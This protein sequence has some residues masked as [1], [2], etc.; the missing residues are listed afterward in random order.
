[1]EEWIDL[2]KE[3]FQLAR[4]AKLICSTAF[5]CPL[6]LAALRARGCSADLALSPHLPPAQVP[7]PSKQGG[8]KAQRSGPPEELGPAVV[9]RQVEVWW[10]PTRQWFEG[11]ICKYNK[12]TRTHLIRY[13][14]FPSRPMHSRLRRE[15]ELICISP[16]DP[17]RTAR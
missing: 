5:P 3:R 1:M 4:A 10:E 15:V 6:S 16:L 9:G 2:G 12:K 17:F 14:S 11:K 7:E 8:E 13:V